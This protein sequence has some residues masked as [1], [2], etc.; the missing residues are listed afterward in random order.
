MKKL[1]FAAVLAGVAY[2]V[3]TRFLRQPDELAQ[4]LQE[5]STLQE[6]GRMAT[7]AHLDALPAKQSIS[8]RGPLDC[9]VFDVFAATIP[10][11]QTYLFPT[12]QTGGV[13]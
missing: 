1:L 10:I 7:G 5:E 4:H 8:N 12:G 2:W 11:A 3:W 13:N 9:G 6:V